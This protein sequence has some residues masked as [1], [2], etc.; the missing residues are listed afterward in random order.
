MKHINIKAYR[1]LGKSNGGTIE[2]INSEQP[3]EE[4]ALGKQEIGKP[5]LINSF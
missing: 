1:K 4:E 5:D 2:E 3:E